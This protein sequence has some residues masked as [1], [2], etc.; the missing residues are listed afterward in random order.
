MTKSKLLQFEDGDSVTVR[1]SPVAVDDLFTVL[2]LLDKANTRHGY[3]DLAD[4]FVPFVESWSFAEPVDATGLLK[5]DVNLLFAIVVGWRDGVR[6]APPPLL[7]TSSD[8]ATSGD[9]SP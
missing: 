6:D 4:G 8:G 2:E 9:E 1:V 3:R 7:V 5:R